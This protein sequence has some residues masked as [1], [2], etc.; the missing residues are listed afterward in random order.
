MEGAQNRQLQY[1][2]PTF[3]GLKGQQK[4]SGVAGASAGPLLFKMEGAQN[5]RFAILK[6][7]HFL[8]RLGKSWISGAS[9]VFGRSEQGLRLSG[10]VQLRGPF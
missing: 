4:R 2:K 7:P 5:R 9:R 10:P 3:S 1:E 6:N 8:T